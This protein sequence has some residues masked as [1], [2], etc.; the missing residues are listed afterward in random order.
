MTDDDPI[1]IA[2][3][4]CRAFEG[5]Y[6]KPYMCPAGVPTIG[7]G[8]TRYENGVRVSLADPP[9]TKERAEELLQWELRTAC[10]PRVMKLCSQLEAWG[11]AAV[12]AIIDFTYN[13]GS[14][15]LAASTLR[16]KIQAD[17]VDG[18]RTELM[19]WVRGGGKVLPG[20]VRRRQ[21]ESDLIN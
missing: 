11:P 8:T 12:A 17:D 21:A 19:K 5:L 2:A 9:I 1:I 16:K 4:L 6:L 20:L 15:N 7:Y 13:L 10:L 18:A 14:G 3:A